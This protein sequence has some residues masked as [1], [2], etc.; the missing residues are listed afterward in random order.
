[1]FKAKVK[2]ECF[3]TG[4][5]E[6]MDI[7]YI[8]PESCLDT[9]WANVQRLSYTHDG[10]GEVPQDAFRN[11]FLV[12]SGHGLKLFTKRDTLN[13]VR[14]DFLSHLHLC[15]HYDAEQIPEEDCWLDLGIEDTP[16]YSD[17]LD[18]GG[19]TL[20]RKL[21]CLDSWAEKFACPDHAV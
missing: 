12:I 13:V 2:Q 7:K 5:G 15:F 6:A 1:D 21:H 9:F 11:P 20:L 4:T 10:D 16:A 18:G 17:T 8:I 3:T 14:S 19:V